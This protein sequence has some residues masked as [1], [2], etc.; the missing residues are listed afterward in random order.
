MKQINKQNVFIFVSILF[1]FTLLIIFSTRFIYYKVF[2]NKQIETIIDLKERIIKKNYLEKE[3]DIY[4]FKGKASTNY[5]TYSSQLWQIAMLKDDEIT[6]ISVKPV[7]N[8]YFDNNYENS[9]INEYLTDDFYNILD[10]SLIINTT[11]CT[12]DIIDSKDICNKKYSKN[13]VLPSLNLY[14]KVGGKES[15]INN[16]YYT[17][18]SNEGNSHYYIDSDGSIG[19][20][21][22]INL[23]GIK[24]LLTIKTANIIS[25]SGV[26]NDPYILDESEKLLKDANVGSYISFSNKLWRIIKND[27]NTRLIANETID[28]FE[29]K[30]EIFDENSKLYKY[31]NK[32][33]IKE[34]NNSYLVKST[35]YNGPFDTTI[36]TLFS[37]VNAYVGIPYI[38]DL[39]LND[40]DNYGLMTYTKYS[41]S[42]HIIN[43]N[44]ITNK[45]TKINIGIRPIISIKNNLKISGDGTMNSPYIIEGEQN[46]KKEA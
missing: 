19:K 37:K 36:K 5:V 6:L 22:N 46:E 30:K 14:E 23:Y 21:N 1:L 17:Y 42:I 13:V 39:Y 20:T 40:I 8:L 16:G 25:G 34:L 2:A 28:N 15:F 10:K 41:S 29:Y 18:L 27:D 3:N 33:F 31:L 45:K 4:Y 35:F 24:A 38:L 11:T 7:T 9:I 44:G 26:R 12:N 32:E 43:N